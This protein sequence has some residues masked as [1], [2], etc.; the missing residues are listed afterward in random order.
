MPGRGISVIYG[1]GLSFTA[2]YAN[3]VVRSIIVATT[4][5]PVFVWG[6]FPSEPQKTACGAANDLDNFTFWGNILKKYG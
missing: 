2:T 5:G 6:S 1:G 4:T 3:D